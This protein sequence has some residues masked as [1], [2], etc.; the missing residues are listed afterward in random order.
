MLCFLQGFQPLR[1]DLML[2][3][4]A[5]KVRNLTGTEIWFFI[6]GRV[7][8]AFGIGVM[9]VRYYPQIAGPL[10]IPAVVVGS[11]L[12]VV[13]AKGLLRPNSN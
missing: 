5:G 13:A 2:N 11:V 1:G 7:L 6:V 12:L 9:G 3:W 4:N 10:G 8:V